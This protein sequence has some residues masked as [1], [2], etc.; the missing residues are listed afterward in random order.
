MRITVIN[1]LAAILVFF[2]GLRTGF[3]E[4]SLAKETPLFEGLELPDI[5]IHG[6]VSQGAFVSTDNDFLGSSEQGTFEFSEAAINVSTEVTDHLR[7]GAQL[8]TRDL[9]PIGNY[10]MVLDWAYIDYRW[11][12]WLGLRAGRIKLPFGLYNEA[13]DVDA[14]RAQILLPQS[15]YPIINRDFLLAQT[16]F[17]LYGRYNF[18]HITP[19][20]AYGLSYQLFGG[21]IFIDHENR[22]LVVRGPFTLNEVSTKYVAGARVFMRTQLPGLVI[23]ATA[24]HTNLGFHFQIDRFA[25]NQLQQ[26]GVF[27]PEF[28]GAFV[29][30]HRDVNLVVG[31]AEYSRGPWVFAAEYSRW[32]FDVI[33]GLAPVVPNLLGEDQERFYGSATYRVTPKLQLGGYFSGLFLDADD[34][35]GKGERFMEPHRAFRKDLAASVRYDIND[36]WLWKA[37]A[38][39][40]NGTAELEPIDPTTLAQHWGFFLIKTTVSF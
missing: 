13:S 17:A 25:L 11:R 30:R 26:A 27:P 38:H 12:D 39:Y 5:Q 34:R 19:S 21:A 3:A 1:R 31:S 7:V 29:Y 33:T 24:L 9:G 35:S 20:W 15:V 40:M 6:F 23:G 8:F 37:E 16:G 14:A 10:K 4:E 36:H 18:G 22:G 2:F 32:M 28:D